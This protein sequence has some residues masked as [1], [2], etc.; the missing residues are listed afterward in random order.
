[1][2]EIASV[3]TIEMQTAQDRLDSK[4][5]RNVSSVFIGCWHLLLPLN[6][7]MFKGDVHEEL[8]VGVDTVFHL[9]ECISTSNKLLLWFSRQN[10]P[11][12][13]QHLVYPL[14]MVPLLGMKFTS[15]SRA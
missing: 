2:Q 4:G 11:S 1:M 3:H 15:L 10:D 6:R 9:P 14:T 13:T 12:K 7:C 8:W 5:Q